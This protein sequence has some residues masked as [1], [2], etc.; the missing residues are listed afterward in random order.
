M[1]MGRSHL[2]FF[3]IRIWVVLDKSSLNMYHVLLESIL[4]FM[5]GPHGVRWH[6]LCIFIFS[7]TMCC[8]EDTVYF[9]SVIDRQSVSVVIV[10][11]LCDV[12]TRIFCKINSVTFVTDEQNTL[13]L[14]RAE[15]PSNLV[16]VRIRCLSV[17]CIQPYMYPRMS[18]P[19]DL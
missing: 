7:V 13:S 12:W 2:C 1:S 16:I 8:L 10:R 4:G 5:L 6:C 3:F 15:G 17:C 11:G 19:S 18:A 14:C 9:W